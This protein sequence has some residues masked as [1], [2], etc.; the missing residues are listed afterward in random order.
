M[1]PKKEPSQ[2]KIK[3]T[4]DYNSSTGLLAR[5]TF[6]RPSS[7]G[8]VGWFSH[9]YIMVCLDYVAYRAHRLIWVMHNGPIPNGFEVGHEDGNPQN[10]RIE[11]LKLVTHAENMKNL[12]RFGNN[13]SGH[14]GIVKHTNGWQARI[15]NRYLGW[16]KDF[17]VALATRKAA[18]IQYNFHPNHGKKET[19]AQGGGS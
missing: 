1:P 9:S 6:G 15:G 3:A 16:F 12:R 18:E 4:F 19:P 13:T 17:N 11:N 14:P 2:D 8:T 5:K 10:N 7:R